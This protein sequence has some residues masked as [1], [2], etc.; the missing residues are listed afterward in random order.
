MA[1]ALGLQDVSVSH[2]ERRRRCFLATTDRLTANS[3][4]AT[5]KKQHMANVVP[6]GRGSQV[7]PTK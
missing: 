2:P 6:L 3:E 1:G 4:R 7:A 5:K